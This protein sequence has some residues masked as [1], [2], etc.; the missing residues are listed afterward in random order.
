MAD[1]FSGNQRS[2]RGPYTRAAAVTPNDSADLADVA[3][4]LWIGGA[5][6]VKV[7]TAGGDA[8]TLSAALAGT[9][10]PVR[11]SRVWATGTAATNIVALR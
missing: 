8:V 2:P 4:A 7:T 6:A 10:I 1:D 11:V 3:S 5:G 9:I